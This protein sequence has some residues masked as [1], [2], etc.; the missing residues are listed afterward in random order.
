MRPVS[1]LLRCARLLVGAT[2]FLGAVGLLS[3]DADASAPS[4]RALLD[5]ALHNATTSRWVHENVQV[6][7]KGVAVQDASDDIG[8][9]EGL[10][11]VSSLG[12]G[13]SEVIAFDHLQT[14]YV[15]ANALGLTSIYS[16]TSTDAA[17]YANE[18][19]SVT[20]SDSEYGSIAYATTLASDFSQVRF[21]GAISESRVITLDGRRVRALKG[22]VPPIDGAPK[23]VGTLY[24]TVTGKALPVTFVERDNKS[25]I[26]VSWADWGHHYVLNTPSGAVTFPTS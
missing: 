3:E 7:Q 4:A 17:T 11:F 13:E 21:A 20:P 9:T 2:I 5:T 10:Q 18:W 15:R 14:L 19:M 24:V 23:F 22:T 25:S 1:L 26:T 8:A 6:K 16:L 12:G